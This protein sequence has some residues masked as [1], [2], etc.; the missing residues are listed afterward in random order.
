MF[1][2]AKSKKQIK[3][4]FCTETQGDFHSIKSMNEICAP[5]YFSI[6]T[7]LLSLPTLFLICLLINIIKNEIQRKI[8]QFTLTN[9]KS[10]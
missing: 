6:I 3:T 9:T 5:T 4:Y 8:N 7:N 2:H 1:T 10:H